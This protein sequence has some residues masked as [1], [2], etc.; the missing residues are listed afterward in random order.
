MMKVAK[1]VFLLSFAIRL[2]AQPCTPLTNFPGNQ[3]ILPDVLPAAYLDAPYT[4]VMQ[5]KAPAD[6]NVVFNNN[7]VRFVVDSMRLVQTLGLP[8]GISF[9]CNPTNCMLLGGQTGC[10]LISG[11]ATAGGVFPIKL[12]V[13]TAGRVQLI[14]QLPQ[15]SIDTNERYTIVVHQNTGLTKVID[16]KLPMTVYPNPAAEKITIKLNGI[17][18]EY[19]NIYDA[20]GKLLNTYHNQ[21]EAEQA[22]LSLAGY[23]SGLYIAERVNAAA[24]TRTRFIIE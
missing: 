12:I 11:Q 5:L 7:T 15:V 14:I 4:A 10:A 2:S 20:S 8:P 23:K 18:G 24:V 16:K 6:T 3:G 21:A 9:E 22:E 1:I 19:V 17:S 13:R